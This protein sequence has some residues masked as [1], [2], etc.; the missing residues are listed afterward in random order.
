MRGHKPEFR[1][2]C[3]S[4]FWWD[5]GTQAGALARI[6][7][8]ISDV[9]PRGRSWGV[10]SRHA[11]PDRLGT[12]KAGLLAE[13]EP[14]AP[15]KQQHRDR[16]CHAGPANA[17]SGGSPTGRVHRRGILNVVFPT[18]FGAVGTNSHESPRRE[19]RL[20]A[21]I[22][23]PVLKPAFRSV[24]ERSARQIRRHCCGNRRAIKHTR[25]PTPHSI[26]SFAAGVHI[27]AFN[28]RFRA[29]A[30]S[31]TRSGLRPGVPHIRKATEIPNDSRSE[32][33]A[34]S[35]QPDVMK[36]CCCER[37]PLFQS[38]AQKLPSIHLQSERETTPP[39]TCQTSLRSKSRRMRAAK[40]HERFVRE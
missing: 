7:A 21:E 3:R 6:G 22:P 16:M 23:N 32:L 27:R 17:Y 34:G 31:D 37:R 14:D 38:L 40:L 20:P 19:R 9:W 28:A 25:P 13:S 1:N 12:L 26:T 10:T 18:M 15:S 2:G 11:R 5:T 35:A 8:S 30:S 4:S 39:N 29:E 36:S 24:I 33:S